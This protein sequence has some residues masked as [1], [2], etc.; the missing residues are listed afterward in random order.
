[1]SKPAFSFPPAWIAVLSLGACFLAW[2][3]WLQI[4][5]A[6]YVTAI[7]RET[8]PATAGSVT[9]YAGGTRELI[10]PEHIEV[11]YEWIAQTQQMFAKG[12]WRVREIDQ[13]NAPYGRRV[14]LASP[15]RWW[16]GLIAWVDHVCSGRP[17]G[18]SVER[19]ALVADP[20]LHLLGLIAATAFV[21]R[22]FGS[23]PASVA[24]VT[25][26]GLFPLSAAFLPAV[27]EDHGLLIALVPWCVLPLV[28]GV[29]ALLVEGG[30][31]DEHER[32]ARGW[33]LMAGVAGGICLWISVIVAV[34][35]L[36]GIALGG[37]LAA[38]IARAGARES[39]T[40]GVSAAP[41]WSWALGG[42]LTVELAY[43]V[44][45]F[46]RHLGAWELRVVHPLYGVA[47]LG[48]AAVLTRSVAWIQQMK[49]KWGFRDVAVF[50]AGFAGLAAVPV[51]MWK[52]TNAGFLA[53]NLQSYR[54]TK[55]MDGVLAPNLSQWLARDGLSPTVCATL[56][57]LLVLAIGLWQVSRRSAAK[58]GRAQL[59][60]VIGPALV[61][62]AFAYF[63]LRWWQ[64]LDSLLVVMAVLATAAICPPVGSGG[65]RLLWLGSLGVVLGVGLF[66]LTPL[67][68]VAAKDV[69][70]LPE[71]EGLVERD[72]A[73]WLAK[74]SAARSSTVVLA[75]P[76]L[77]STLNFYGGLRG[78]GTLSWENK[79][80]LSV[81]LRIVISTS[82]EEAEALIRQRGVTH[83]VIPS[84]NRFFEDYTR[85]AGVQA[86]EMFYTSLH[87][88]A[89]PAW[90]RPIP[91]QLP[92]IAGFDEQ[93]VMI[94]EVVDEQT[95][96]AA[97]SRLAEYFLEMGQL[98]NARAVGQSLRRF[99]ADLGALVARAQVEVARRD[100]I[101]FK[102]LLDGI[103]K[104]IAT[105][106]DRIMSWDRRLSLAVVLARGQRMDLAR[107]QL[108]RCLAEIDETRIRAL[109]THALFHLET[110]R[111]NLGLEIQ[112]ARLREVIKDL[113]PPE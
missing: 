71:V 37:M 110:L 66:Q 11:C 2:S 26:L 40:G 22:Q 32:R 3:A 107:V 88:W 55:Q 25:I 7:A 76:G 54:L 39:T 98:D 47:W 102:E 18:L 31:A 75:P 13:E 21:A 101:A 61:A 70:S 43:L 96:P 24:A 69:L 108:E 77:T 103:V 16:L 46:P 4:R 23:L 64:I 85:P 59:A 113:S 83:I 35:L 109:T 58:P 1:M 100:A 57:P 84:W 12:E 65:K 106:G 72:L 36:L 29:R 41:W 111:R 44:E 49:L 99:P 60:V 112:P 62:L 86:G 82:R 19:A 14:H 17:I 51:V 91:F 94:L 45:Y 6:E 8:T 68:G 93:S 27:P 89:L 78:L 74:H 15:Y 38:W 105:G 42:S 34:P 67:K 33:F 79:D 81:A 9:G 92:K 73:H 20:L 104:R 52:T 53:I 10:V 87:R 5:R 63:Q 30:T 28:V 56:L 95:E 80:G 48:G 50:L 90:L 97:M